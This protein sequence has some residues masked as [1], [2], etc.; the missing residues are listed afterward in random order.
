MLVLF[1]VWI[2]ACYKAKINCASW[3]DPELCL[4]VYWRR[5]CLLLGL[6]HLY[7]QR[8][9]ALGGHSER[10]VFHSLRHAFKRL[11]VNTVKVLSFNI[12]SFMSGVLCSS[13]RQSLCNTASHWEKDHIQRT[14]YA[15]GEGCVGVTMKQNQCSNWCAPP[16]EAIEESSAQRSQ[17]GWTMTM[18]SEPRA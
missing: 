18:T 8:L 3:L 11:T 12:I 1:V 9:A 2:K 13:S 10:F 17:R 4:V 5:G 6:H 15:N 16:D 14:V 7:H